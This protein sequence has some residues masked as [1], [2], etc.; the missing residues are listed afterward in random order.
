[1]QIVDFPADDALCIH[2]AAQMLV[3]A[4][5]AHWPNAW[6]DLDAALEEV[7]EALQPDV[8]ARA[9]LDDDHHVLGWTAARP[10]YDGLAWELHPLVVRS[11]MQERGIGRALVRDLEQQVAAHGGI[12][13]YLG[14]DDEDAMTSLAGRDLY[15][16]VAA[17]LAH[18]VN[19]HRHP[20]EF[21]QKQGFAVVGVIP[22]AKDAPHITT[23]RSPNPYVTRTHGKN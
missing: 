18:I 19:L 5:A 10:E 17:Q 13:L 1:M 15:P 14:T 2:Q 22:D 23:Y 4:F 12:T 3:N 7:H 11:D 6:P 20:F 16:D 9:A 21:Y 8:I